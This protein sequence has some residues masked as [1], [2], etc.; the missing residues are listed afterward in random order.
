MERMYIHIHPE[1][2]LFEDGNLP[3][4]YKGK[5]NRRVVTNISKD[6]FDDTIEI[7]CALFNDE[8]K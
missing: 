3:D 8:N 2:Y 1:T 7:C 5:F 6:K 4:E